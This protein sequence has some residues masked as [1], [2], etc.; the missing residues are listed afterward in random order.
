M[1]NYPTQSEMDPPVEYLFVDHVISILRARALL[2]LFNWFVK[3]HL[4][5][6]SP[7]ARILVFT[8]LIPLFLNLDVPP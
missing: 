6:T 2:T 3:L 5:V 7:A 1:H 8:F 4:C